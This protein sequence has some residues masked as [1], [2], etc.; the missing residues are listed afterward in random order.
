M[1]PKYY[2]FISILI[3]F[4]L[5]IC[6][7]QQQ[8]KARVTTNNNVVVKQEQKTEAEDFEV[9]YRNFLTD[10]S[11]QMSRIHFPLEGYNYEGGE[12]TRWDKSNWQLQKIS[13]YDID[14]NEYKKEIL[15]TDSAVYTRI[16]K[17]DSDIDI[18]NKFELIE[19]KWFLTYHLNIFN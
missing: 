10:D 18:R 14:T 12:K 11:F 16:Y 3:L 17:D 9:F 2:Y 8:E 13:I 15:K 6:C 4:S 19:G 7:I 1:R 5:L